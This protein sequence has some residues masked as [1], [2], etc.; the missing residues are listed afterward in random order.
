MRHHSATVSAAAEQA[1]VLLKHSRPLAADFSPAAAV[2]LLR[3]LLSSPS[4]P[5]RR[6]L[7][8][9]FLRASQSFPFF[10]PPSPP[11]LLL[12]LLHLLSS[13]R[14]YSPALSLARSLLPLHPLPNLLPSLLSLPSPPSLSPL[15]N[16]LIK[17][18][19]SLGLIPQAI[20]IID[21]TD[22]H[23]FSLSILAYNSV[24]D[25][26]FRASPPRSDAAHQFHDRM[27]RSGVCLNAYSYNILI[28]GFCAWGD[29]LR[30]FSFFHEMVE[31]GEKR[32]MEADKVVDEMVRLGL[33]PDEVTYNTIMNGYCK[34]GDVHRA[35]VAH[36]EMMRRGLK[37]NVVTYTLLID[38]MCKA[39]NL[40]KAME[41]VEQM[42][43][44][45]IG[46]NEVTYTALVDG[47]CKKGFLDDAV[48]VLNEMKMSGILPSVVCYNALVHGYCELGRMLEAEGIV[49]EMEGNGLRLDK[50][51]FGTLLNGYRK[52]GDLEMAFKLN[53]EMLDK[54]ILPD[55]IAY[56][57]LIRGLCEARK[58]DDAFG[59]FKQ[60]LSV[61]VLPD[62]ITYTTL[63]DGCCKEGDVKKAFALHDEM[64]RKGILPDVV[65]YSVLINGLNKTS[66]TKEARRLL[67]KLYYE[68]PVPDNIMYDALMDCCDKAD[69]KGTVSLIKSFCMK[70]MIT[71]A[72]KV[73]D[74]MTEKGGKL[75]E[76]AHNVIIRG[77]CRAGNVHKALFLYK[78]MLKLGFVPNTISTIS[79]IRGLSDAGMQTDMNE[80]IQELLRGSM[81]T[82]AE[83]SKVL[84]EVN[85]REGN[86]EAVLNVLTEMAN[87]GLLP[88]GAGNI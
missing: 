63:I 20:S 42:R 56:S 60:M 73:F 82:D 45:E 37:P 30:G 50:V 68:E 1:L 27:A 69:S 46:L 35:L 25:S 32:A 38:A 15:L 23:G 57:S 88:N 51:T 8:L 61:S 43:E 29:L 11:L 12:L 77:H 48:V 54:G 4:L 85:H 66:R 34:E 62:E 81:L 13:L 19:S 58:L 16:L 52:N 59:L 40:K 39:G 72:E 36:A 6:S 55:A 21:F 87:D 5:R 74:S 10:S 14:L 76:A 67:F 83:T 47:F 9:S 41:F 26:I 33:A 71:E 24:L 78:D 2:H 28:R 79:L 44:R 65:T 17:S 86:I 31:A 70:G 18:Y 22:S 49:R 3:H 75:V 80:V 64:T 53:Q 7:S 84:I